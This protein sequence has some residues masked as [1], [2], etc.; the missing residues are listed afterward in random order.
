MALSAVEELTQ[1]REEAEEAAEPPVEAMPKLDRDSFSYLEP[2][3]GLDGLDMFRC[4]S[5]CQSFCPEV[6]FTG[7]MFGSRCAILGSLL[8]VSDDNY[9]N[10]YT[11]WSSGIP[12]SN[13]VDTNVAELRR[14]VPPAISPEA[15]GYAWDASTKK[16]CC[17]CRFFDGAESECEAFEDLN[18]RAPGLF[19]LD[20]KVAPRGG[21]SMWSM[22]AEL[23]PP[24]SF[25]P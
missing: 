22:R 18:N 24:S 17:E 14:G 21:C 7:A 1:H 15:A 5:S 20:T 25:S 23:L 8:K 11:P 9:C 3:P 13:I 4:C 2:R 12:C 19:N 10:H 16:Q 6:N